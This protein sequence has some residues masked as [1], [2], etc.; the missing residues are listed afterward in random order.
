[1]KKLTTSKALALLATATLLNEDIISFLNGCYMDDR[2]C[3]LNGT[4]S[5][6]MDARGGTVLHAS[7][8]AALDWK[9]VDAFLQEIRR[10][11]TK[12]KD[13]RTFREASC[14]FKRLLSLTEETG[15]EKTSAE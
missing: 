9:D 3:D 15:G 4:E 12:N 11:A 1:M 10:E 14:L 7:V 5:L 13:F 8:E 6:I 2:Y